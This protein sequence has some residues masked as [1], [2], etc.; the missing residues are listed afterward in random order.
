MEENIN[1]INKELWQICKKH[2]IEWQV[3]QDP[4]KKEK[5][6]V[7]KPI[8]FPAEVNM[9]RLGVFT[10]TRPKKIVKTENEYAISKKYTGVSST[11]ESFIVEIEHGDRILG[12]PEL[13]IWLIFQYFYA[14]QMVTN[15]DK[16]IAYGRKIPYNYAQICR[17][18]KIEPEGENFGRIRSIIKN[19]VKTRI[20]IRGFYNKGKRQIETIDDFSIFSHARNKYEKYKGRY[21]GEAHYVVINEVLAKNID[22]KYINTFDLSK[23]MSVKKSIALGLYLK[24]TSS[25]YG[26][27]VIPLYFTYKNLCFYCQIPI[28]RINYDIDR[29]FKPALEELVRI[30]FLAKYKWEDVNKKHIGIKFYPGSLYYADRERRKQLSRITGKKQLSRNFSENDN[31]E[32]DEFEKDSYVDLDKEL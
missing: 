26:S 7:A 11:G 16:F 9:N 19:L 31:N 30:R 8:I 20:E 3:N 4:V 1:N 28:Y 24:L 2:G 13:R 22:N 14:Q 23:L 6:E 18:L 25:F 5:Q 29:Q 15:R 32:N 21:K 10:L 27:P 17:L 12:A